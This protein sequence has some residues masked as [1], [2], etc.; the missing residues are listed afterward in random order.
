MFRDLVEVSQDLTIIYARCTSFFFIC[1]DTV[2]LD[3]VICD[4]TSQ[5]ISTQCSYFFLTFKLYINIASIIYI[6]FSYKYL[7]K[8][9]VVKFDT[10]SF[11]LAEKA[12]S[13]TLAWKIPGMG[14]PGGLPSMGLHRV[15]H[16][17]SDLAVAAA[18]VLELTNCICIKYV[19]LTEKE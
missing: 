9:L 16:N 2:L 18:F 12:H 1:V 10:V 19:L 11:V 5:F 3:N 6:C 7:S 17:C 4:F 14:E 13:S 15:G 8:V